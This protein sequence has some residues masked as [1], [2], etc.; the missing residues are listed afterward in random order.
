M[1]TFVRR[2]AML[3]AVA[4]MCQAGSSLA[5]DL[6]Y[7]SDG[8]QAITLVGD[9]KTEPCSSGCVEPSC[10]NACGGCCCKLGCDGCSNR[11]IVAFAGLDSFKGISD[12]SYESNFGAVAGVNSAL[13]LPIDYNLGWQ[14]GMSYGVYDLDGWGEHD[15]TNSSTS[16]Q[17]IFIT[18]G[19]FHKANEDRRLSYGLVYDWMVN[20]EWGVYGTSPTLGQWRGQIEYALSGCNAVG[21]WGCVNDRYSQQRSRDQG[22]VRNAGVTQANL[23]WHHKFCSGADSW[24]WVGAPERSALTGDGSLGQWMVGANVQVPL[25]ETLALYANGSYFRPT[26]SAGGDAAMAQGYDVSMGV[27]WYFGGRAVNHAIN[28]DCGLPYMPLAN[29]SNFLVDQN[30][31]F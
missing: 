18:T 21:V 30:H 15:T 24:L 29:N 26:A 14:L 20:D 11:G 1:K 10:E 3:M 28:G 4:A 6:H 23:F 9:Q 31:S 8:S 2:A 22:I 12:G 25:S 13:L 5:E 19:F 27:A 7:V 17:Q 16:Q